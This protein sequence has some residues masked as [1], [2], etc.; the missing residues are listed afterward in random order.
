MEF[1]EIA[2]KAYKKEKL[3]KN[4]DV[5]T[6]YAFLRL[7]DLYSRFEFGEIDKEKSIMEKKKIEK[8]YKDDRKYYENTLEVYK[9]YNDNRIEGQMLLANIE[10]SKDK[11]EIIKDALKLIA[12][13]VKDDTFVKRNFEKLNLN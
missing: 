8:E 5:S 12:K 13:L 9:E 10:K 3:D 2:K 7:K 11:D 4:W 6:K 1:E